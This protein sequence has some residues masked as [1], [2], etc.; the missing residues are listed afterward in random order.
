MS[1]STLLSGMRVVEVSAFVAAPLGGMTLAQLGADVIRID[2]P[3]GGLDFHRWPVTA[4]GT[5]LFWC[6][7]NKAKRSVAIDTSK[8]EG[9]ELAIAL[10][11]A[12]AGEGT[13]GGI[14]LSNLP[15]AGWRDHDELRKRRAD[16][17]Q[18]TLMGDRKG[19]SAVD[20]TV[21]PGVGLPAITG[22]ED[23]DQPV[24]H[25][26]PAWDL[27]TGQMVALGLLAAERHRRLTGQGQ[28]VKLALED[29]ALATMGNLGFH[30]EAELGSERAR[31]GN[32]MFGTFGR[33]FVCQDGRRV[34]VVAVT[35]KQWRS[36]V[37]AVGAEAEIGELA[38]THGVNL[39]EEGARFVHRVAI[40]AIVER[41]VASRTFAEVKAVLDQQQVC[42]GLYRTVRETVTA[43]DGIAAN[44]LFARTE[45][46]GVGALTVAGH[47][48]NL[49]AA[50]ARP[51]VTAP[52]LGQHTEEVLAGLLG[53]TTGQLGALEERGIIALP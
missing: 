49:P 7:L 41:W 16:L 31:Y 34:M 24:N 15:P 37:T 36:L 52:R 13:D 44:P 5:S 1:N 23:T 46:P 21:N 6:G 42:W 4:D 50:T 2:P 17:I 18:L 11:C 47:P 33:D 10:V 51:P 28:H 29:V 26:L 32:A 20:Y 22:A 14:F 38:R 40:A 25:V 43:P 45:Q 39:D 8:P 3:G 53:L 19:G 12:S 35:A 30:A 48:L 9:R 27:I